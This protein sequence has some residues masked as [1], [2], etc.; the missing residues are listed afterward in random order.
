MG[1]S[2]PRSGGAGVSLCLGCLMYV[3]TCICVYILIMSILKRKTKSPPVDSEVVDYPQS[4]SLESGDTRVLKT[5][6]IKIHG[7]TGPIPYG[8][9]DHVVVKNQID[10][11]IKTSSN[12]TLTYLIHPFWVGGKKENTFLF[13]FE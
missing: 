8:S 10:T 2:L 6:P 4:S 3:H 5:L 11:P 13:S 1:L 7:W 9:I 12:R